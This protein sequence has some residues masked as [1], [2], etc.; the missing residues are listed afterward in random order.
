M[1]TQVQQI[2]DQIIPVLK[3]AGVLRCGVFGSAARG[4]TRAESDVDILVEL[5]KEKTLFD[6]VGLKLS[7]EETLKKKVDLV[8]YTTI[9]SQLRD[10]ILQEQVQIL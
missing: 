5:P 6:F 2:K 7:L 9:K 1:T 4:E 10:V 8:E 3:Q